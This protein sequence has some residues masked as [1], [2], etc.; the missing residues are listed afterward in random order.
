VKCILGVIYKETFGVLKVFAV[1][2][3]EHANRKTMT[4]MDVDYAL[5]RQDHTLYG[6][7]G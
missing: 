4:A 6:F 1:M 5:E 7:G 3:T 2:Y